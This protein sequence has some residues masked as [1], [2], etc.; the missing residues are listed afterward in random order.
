MPFEI[1][2]WCQPERGTPSG[3][4][5]IGRWNVPVVP[6]VGEHIALHIDYSSL[7]VLR[8][9]HEI[10]EGSV[11]I[12]IPYLSPDEWPPPREGTE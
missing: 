1:V 10:Y 9:F 3:A 12:E 2:V 5:E 4:R 7:E 6:R 11:H 8:V